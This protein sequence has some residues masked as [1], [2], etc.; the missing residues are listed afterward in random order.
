MKVVC[1]TQLWL[2]PVLDDDVDV[3][4][5][6]DAHGAHGGDR[7]SVA[8]HVRVRAEGIHNQTGPVA[9]TARKGTRTVQEGQCQGHTT[10]RI[11]LSFSPFSQI[12][13]RAFKVQRGF[14]N[15]LQVTHLPPVWDLLLSLA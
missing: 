9:P 8:E 3:S 11:C 10:W 13:C 14:V 1:K 4:D 6:R 7:T 12:L 5:S 15:P 2:P